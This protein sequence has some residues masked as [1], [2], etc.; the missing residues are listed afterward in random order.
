MVRAREP[1][2]PVGTLPQRV[3]RDFSGVGYGEAMRR[4][5]EIVPILRE[6]AQRAEDARMLIR[7]NEQLLHETGLFRF[8]QPK[9]FGGM[10]LPFVAVVDIPA[11]LGRGCP[12][13]AWNVGNV[14]CHHWILGYYAPETQREVWD[15][16]PNALIASSI[17]LAA[18][19]G[20]KTPGG[21]IVNGRWPFSSAVD[22][23]EWNM[24]AG[25]V[26]EDDGQTALRL[27]GCPVAQAHH[28][29]IDTQDRRRCGPRRQRRPRP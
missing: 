12:S 15:A 26:Y 2:E 22:N 5:R 20:R 29:N 24:L 4:A 21:F 13:T 18:G 6:R 16:N 23:S 3:R 11:E 8:H 19:R 9:G 17:A 28:Q 14:A 7:E 25:T 10:E 1:S 27:R